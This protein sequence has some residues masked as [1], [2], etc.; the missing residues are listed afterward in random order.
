MS[1]WAFVYLSLSSLPSVSS[2]FSLYYIYIITYNL[3]CVC[4][5]VWRAIEEISYTG[6]SLYDFIKV[7]MS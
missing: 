1:M 3:Y 7:R 6:G 2:S 4:L 5:W